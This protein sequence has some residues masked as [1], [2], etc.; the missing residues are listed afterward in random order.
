MRKKGNGSFYK[1]ELVNTCTSCGYKFD[2][3]D[4][5]DNDCGSFAC[6]GCNKEYYA[7]LNEDNELVIAEGHNPRCGCD[8]DDDTD[9]EQ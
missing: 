8:T 3:H 2:G 4:V 5:C 1:W 7:Q 9:S 6:Y